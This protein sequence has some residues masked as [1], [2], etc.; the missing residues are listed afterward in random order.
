[1]TSPVLI[2]ILICFAAGLALITIVC[3]IRFLIDKL[4]QS[5][6]QDETESEEQ[7]QYEPSAAVEIL[8]G[9][10]EQFTRTLK[11]WKDWYITYKQYENLKR[12]YQ[13]T[14]Q[15]IAS[16]SEDIRKEKVPR[17]DTFLHVYQKLPY[18]ISRLNQEYIQR[19]LTNNKSFFDS[20]RGKSLDLQ[21]RLVCVTDDDYTLVVAGAGSGKTVTIEAKVKYLVEK[22][23]VDPKEILVTSFTDKTVDE[24]KERIG[25]ININVDVTTFHAL[26]LKII[27]DN[28][29]T[30]ISVADDNKLKHEIDNYILKITEGHASSPTKY[31]TFFNSY[32]RTYNNTNNTDI[33][34]E[35][36]RTLCGESVKSLGEVT[37][38]NYLY[39]HGVN[40]KYEMLHPNS[41]KDKPYHP[42]FYLPDYDLYLE[43]FGINRD[44]TA[45][46]FGKEGEKKYLEQMAWKRRFHAE[47]NT[48]LL[49]TY[50][51]YGSGE[52]LEYHLEALLQKHNVPLKERSDKEL[53][54]ILLRQMQLKEFDFLKKNIASFINLYKL[55]GFSG[56]PNEGFAKELEKMT[57]FWRKRT[58]LF[59]DIISEIYQEYESLLFLSD[60]VDFSDMITKATRIIDEGGTVPTYCYIIVDEYQDS[61]VAI[62]RFINSL[63]RKCGAKVLCA[64]DDWQS[65]YRFNGGDVDLFQ[66]FEKYFSHPKI[67]KI[68]KTYRNPQEL[69]DI[70]GPFITKNPAQISK[71]M[72]SDKHIQSPVRIVTYNDNMLKHL[73]DIVDEIA[74]KISPKASVMILG[75]INN[76]IKS[77]FLPDKVGQDFQ[78]KITKNKTHL[79]SLIYPEM[80]FSVMTIHKSKGLEADAVIILNMSNAT[81]GFPNQI[82]DDYILSLV[83]KGKEMYPFAEERRVFYVAATRA[84]NLLYLLTPEDKQLQ[85]RFTRELIEDAALSVYELPRQTNPVNKNE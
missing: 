76:D 20:I 62:Y 56:L 42:D 43:H 18:Y 78:I 53:S 85:S 44:G 63:S 67:L 14:A 80:K 59:L 68:E 16:L 65:I 47:H 46:H 70:I 40:Y 27:K 10:V 7:F 83:K 79:K 21:Q 84:K 28:D 31:L 32:Y 15:Q 6:K 57:P 24:L 3:L 36:Y 34:S 19:E 39:L 29:Y 17:F 72:V 41:P 49:E 50:A 13:N 48:T 37:I 23:G 71:K 54:D 1:M 51:Y 11:K 2:S 9:E 22:K 61:S 38:A 73:H 66:N 26:G 82:S 81:L 45:P 30:V 5:D 35:R 8:K 12:E 69:L 74:E 60:S 77:Q 25:N 58:E 33:L 55:N 75:R 4:K 64:G 52:R